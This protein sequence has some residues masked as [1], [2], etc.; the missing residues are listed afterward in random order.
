MNSRQ[1]LKRRLGNRFRRYTLSFNPKLY[2]PSSGKFITGDALR[3]K[4]DFI[5]DETKTFNPSLVKEKDVVFLKT[6]LKEIYFKIQH[7]NIKNKYILITHNSD[8]IIS[9][10]DRKYKD[11]KIIHW[12]CQN[13]SFESNEH[14][15]PMPIGFENRRFLNHGRINNLKKVANLKIRKYN[16]ILS[17]HN[18]KTNKKIRENLEI[19]IEGNENIVNQR[20]DKH[21][22]YLKNLTK[23]KFI[24]CPEGNGLDTHRIWE[25]ILTNT[26]PIVIKNE[27]TLN[28]KKIGV[29]LLLINDWTD[30]KI[31]NESKIE[32][33][34]NLFKDL[35]FSQFV[36]IK[37]WTDQIGNKK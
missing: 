30:L 7:P 13:L 32:E 23:Y 15:S 36:E 25:S 26:V 11:E 37:F 27:F 29:P 6:D 34:Y 18:I 24:L 17:S 21:L 9:N 16:K 3:K 33:S 22:D 19:F 31:F 8:Q 10:E 28:L 12:F 14:F 1:S 20:F 35:K 5:F 4:S 2:R